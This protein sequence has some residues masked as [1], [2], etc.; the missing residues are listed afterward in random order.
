MSIQLILTE[1]RLVVVE[2]DPGTSADCL[3]PVEEAALRGAWIICN[4]P[5]PGDNRKIGLEVMRQM[6]D[7]AGRPWPQPHEGLIAKMSEALEAGRISERE[8]VDW[9]CL[10]VATA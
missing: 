4:H 8:F 1:G 6:L 10:R 3:S 5:F 9:V 2:D 7:E